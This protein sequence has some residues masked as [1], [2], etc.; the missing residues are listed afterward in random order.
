MHTA[1]D[2]AFRT[3]AVK[4]RIDGEKLAVSYVADTKNYIDNKLNEIATAIVA[5]A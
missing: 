2:L 3:S 5:N 4:R 1:M